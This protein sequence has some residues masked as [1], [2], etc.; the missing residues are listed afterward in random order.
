MAFKAGVSG[1]PGGRPKE[2]PEVKEAARKHTKAALKTLK[3]IM[4]DRKQ[5]GS[6]R[7]AAANALLDRG[8]GKAA[9]HI[10]ADVSHSWESVAASEFDGWLTGLFAPG[11]TDT[12]R[13]RPN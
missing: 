8:Y 2:H 10:S 7:V 13:D 4:S 5:P 1:N 11:V 9:Q 3:T 6:A 12:E